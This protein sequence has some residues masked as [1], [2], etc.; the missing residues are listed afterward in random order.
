MSKKQPSLFGYIVCSRLFVWDGGIPCEEAVEVPFV[1]VDRRDVDDPMKCE[2]IG[3]AWYDHGENHRVENGKIARD[4]DG[5]RWA[6]KISDIAELEAFC[7]KY[8]DVSLSVNNDGTEPCFEIE[9]C[10]IMSSGT[11]LRLSRNR[12]PLGVAKP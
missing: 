5:K 12:L 6:V 10:S 8:K 4:I 7:L 3:A 1:W 2:H 9:I 11:V